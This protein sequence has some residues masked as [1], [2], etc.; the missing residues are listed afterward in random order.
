MSGDAVQRK[1]DAIY[2]PL[3]NII[4]IADDIIIWGDEE[5]GSDHNKTLACFL[6]VT[7]EN[8]LRINFDKIQ[9]KTTEVTFFG[10][11][12]TTK[13]HKPATDKVQAITQMPTPTNV[14]ELQTFFWHVP[15]PGQILA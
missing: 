2:N 10:E 15:I 14:T 9:Y 4:G 7:R 5:D 6:Q 13:G 1:T 11:T 8:G 3:P 12:Y